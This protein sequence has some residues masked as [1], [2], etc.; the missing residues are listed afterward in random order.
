MSQKLQSISGGESEPLKTKELKL[1][2]LDAQTAL[3]EIKARLKKIE[4]KLSE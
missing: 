4:A 1:D 3:S 2:K